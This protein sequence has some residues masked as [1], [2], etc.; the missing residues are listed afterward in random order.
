MRFALVLSSISA[1]LIA[2]LCAV[3]IAALSWIY[4]A[5]TNQERGHSDKLPLAETEAMK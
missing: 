4:P 2:V 5:Y 1:L 3:S